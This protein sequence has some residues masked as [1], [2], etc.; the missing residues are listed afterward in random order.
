MGQSLCKI[1]LH[2]VFHINTKSPIILDQDL[3]S[4]HRYIGKMVNTTGSQTLRVGGVPNHIHV[5]CALGKQ[6]NVAH[7]VEEMKRNSSRWI[8]T[9]SPHYH[10]F[11]WQSGYAAFSVSQSALEKTIEYVKN[12]KE[13]HQKRTYKDE[14]LT[15]LNLYNVEYNE[16]YVLSD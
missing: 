6:E 8:K 12:Q 13:H 14:Y 4:L 3:E 16:Q 15:F 7:L 2:I 5:V 9:L 11:A 1:Y 10:S